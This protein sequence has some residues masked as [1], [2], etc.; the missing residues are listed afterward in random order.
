MD[1][2]SIRDNRPLN[3]ILFGQTRCIIVYTCLYFYV[4]NVYSGVLFY[5]DVYFRIHK[6]GVN[7][8][9]TMGMICVVIRP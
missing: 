6:V 7:I 4:Y 2:V 3:V 8:S 9:Q 5:F 1:D